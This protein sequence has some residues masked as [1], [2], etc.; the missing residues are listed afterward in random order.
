MLMPSD[1][2][3]F[4]N[5]LYLVL[6]WPVTWKVISGMV[7]LP[8]MMTHKVLSIDTQYIDNEYNLSILFQNISNWFKNPSP[9][10][11]KVELIC[12][13]LGIEPYE[14]WLSKEDH[15]NKM[16]IPDH[17]VDFIVFFKKQKP[18]IQDLIMDVTFKLCKTL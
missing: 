5:F 18:E 4:D 2:I 6:T 17:L 9:P 3:V 13:G 12:S 15:A 1:R 10:I 16:Q 11:G 8:V 14:L 7:F